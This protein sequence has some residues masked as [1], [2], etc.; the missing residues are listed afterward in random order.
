MAAYTGEGGLKDIRNRLPREYGEVLLD[1][2]GVATITFANPAPAT[3]QRFIQ[4]TPWIES[5]D[6]PVIANPIEWI[7][8]GSDYTGV[9]IK[10]QRIRS[11]PNTIL[12]LGALQ[13]FLAVTPDTTAGVGVD[14]MLY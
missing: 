9:I 8:S 5:D 13:G 2:S 11:L 3:G 12:N 14:W 4:L 7:S 6:A 1:A 10:G